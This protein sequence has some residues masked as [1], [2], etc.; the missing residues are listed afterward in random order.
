[1]R[2]IRCAPLVGEAFEEGLKGEAGA[3]LVGYFQNLAN[4]VNLS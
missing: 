4:L 2:R 3:F 1:M